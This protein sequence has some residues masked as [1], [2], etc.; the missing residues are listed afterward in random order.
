MSLSAAAQ[1]IRALG[2]VYVGAGK[3]DYV[4]IEKREAVEGLRQVPSA[5]EH[6]G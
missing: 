6:G 3:R 5:V 4:P 2:Q 1:L